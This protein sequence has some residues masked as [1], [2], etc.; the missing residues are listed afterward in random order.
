MDNYRQLSKFYILYAIFNLIT[1]D[2]ILSYKMEHDNKNNILIYDIEDIKKTGNIFKEKL[3]ALIELSEYGNGKL[4]IYN[5]KLYISWNWFQSLHRTLYGES[6]VKIVDFLKNVFN[7]YNIYI[8]MINTCITYK[9]HL[10]IINEIKKEQ[11]ILNNKWFVGIQI[12]KNQYID[13]T[14][15]LKELEKIQMNYN[16][17]VQCTD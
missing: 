5:D 10:D 2:I 6:R 17:C 15:V 7:D 11:L 1:Y 16:V 12:L 8:K 14:D 9:H 13:D 3:N 4:G